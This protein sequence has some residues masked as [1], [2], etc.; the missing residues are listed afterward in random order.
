[1]MRQLSRWLFRLKAPHIPGK[2]E[3]ALKE[4]MAFHLEME[5]RRLIGEGLTPE[6]ATR[7]ARRAFG[8][9]EYHKEKARENWGIGMI[10]DF[11]R[12]A[13][14]TL[15][16]LKRNPGFAFV[17]ILTLGLGIGANSAIFSVVNGILL[18]GL[19]FPEA[20]RLVSICETMPNEGRCATASTPNVADWAER[21]SSFEEIG[22]FRWWGHILETPD[23]AQSVRSLIATPQFF[24]VMGYEP[25]IGRVLQAE[26]QMEG[27]RHVA[28]LDHDFWQSRFGGDPD[29]VGTSISLGGEAFQVIGVLRPGQKPPAMSGEPQADVWLPLHFDPRAND[30]RDWRGFYAVGRLAD[31]ATFEVAEQE[32][33]VIRQGLIEEHPRENAEWGMQMGT[34][35]DRIVGGVKTTLFFFLGAV[36]LVLL[37]TCANI[38]NLILARMSARET[39]LGIRTALGA[40]T[41]RLVGLLLNEGLVLAFLGSTVGLAIAWVGTPFFISL[42]PAGIPRL[43]EVGMDGRVLV[44]TMLLTLF[45][46]LLFGLA[47]LARASRVQPMM[48]LRGGRHGRP[49][50]FLGGTNGILVVSEVALALSLLVGAGLLT[51]SFASFFQWDPGIDREHLL[52][53]SNSSMTGT[54]ETRESIINLYRN[55]DEELG[56]LPGVR[57]V[58]RGSAGPLFG[59]WEPDQILPAEEAESGGAGHQARWYDI[60]PRYFETLG[61]P[62][63]QGRDFNFDDGLESTQVT[64]VNETLANRLWPGENPL[65]KRIWLELHDEVREVVGLVADV[66]P[67]NPDGVVGPEMFWPQAQYTRPF[68]YFILRTEGDPS[69]VRGQIEDRIKGVDPNLQVGATRSYDELVER[70]LVQP[71]FNMLLIGIFSAVAM[72]LAAVGIFGVVSRSVAARTREIGIRIA[73]G[74]PASQVVREV[75]RN[76]LVLAGVGIGVGLILAFVLSRFIR[77]ML[78]GVTATD[79]LTYGLVAVILFG[80]AVLASLIPASRASRV[81]PVTSLREE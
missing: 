62:I 43:N 25:L 1:M 79:P 75:S 7:T 77:S 53:V 47:P 41:P 16:S 56:A 55:L 34:L 60:S 8:Q 67:L 71:R 44:F 40:S 80:V 69:T 54:Y 3:E 28:V 17:A 66:P 18:Q 21:S 31:G 20:D 35:Q 76:S 65:G 9:A 74:A 14:H 72:I 68:T 57:G 23:R 32:L 51:R 63:L 22:V 50:G 19:P 10:Q 48:A 29:L 26:D 37:I 64:I 13:L 81:S 46:T 49:K 12:D 70:R 38:A 36:G 4:E 52:V 42:A 2:L 78:H 15:R 58:A 73:L 39:E 27:G 24:Q 45:A 33:G 11:R 6:E 5:T 61:V 59:G 30:R